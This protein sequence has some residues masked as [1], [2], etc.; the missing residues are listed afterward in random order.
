GDIEGRERFIK[1]WGAGGKAG[2]CEGWERVRWSTPDSCSHHLRPRVANATSQD[3]QRSVTR[4]AA[5]SPHSDSLLTR[6]DGC[7]AP[8]RLAPQMAQNV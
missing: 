8:V 3:R 2:H 6:S 4:S 1:G 5:A 7:V